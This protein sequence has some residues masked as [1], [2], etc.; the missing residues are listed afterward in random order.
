MSP[1]NLIKLHDQLRTLEMQVNFLQKHGILQKSSKCEK[2]DLVTDKVLAA[3]ITSL[4]A[5]LEK[6]N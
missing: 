5:D 2:C 4:S 3:N 6:T 1:L